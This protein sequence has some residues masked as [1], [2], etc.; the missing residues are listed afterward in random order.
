MEAFGLF[1]LSVILRLWAEY[2]LLEFERIAKIVSIFY[3][4]FA[5]PDVC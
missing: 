1:A 3:M 2:S 4:D 5:F